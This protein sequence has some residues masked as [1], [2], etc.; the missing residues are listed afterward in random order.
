MTAAD[1]ETLRQE[2]KRDEGFSPTP[3]PDTGGN[4]TIGYGTN[5]SAGISEPEADYLL[6]GRMDARWSELVRAFPYVDTLDGVRQ[7]VLGNMAY[8]LGLR[9]LAGFAL[10]WN[11]I[12]V[13]D[14]DRAAHEML[15]SRWAQQVGARA[16]RLAEAMRSGE[17]K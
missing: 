17:I 1:Y 16:T 15:G 11:A 13:G 8:N 12:R 2:L 6:R 9:R 14:F 4:L 10:M 3:Y 5:L 7:I